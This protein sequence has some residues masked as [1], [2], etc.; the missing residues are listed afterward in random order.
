MSW[1]SWVITIIF[2][3]SAATFIA[4]STLELFFG[5]R[6]S[7]PLSL[8]LL[9]LTDVAGLTMIFMVPEMREA[10]R[11]FLQSLEDKIS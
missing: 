9:G 7:E 10:N 8:L 3:V 11:K 1:G 5:C 2:C 6:F 4:V